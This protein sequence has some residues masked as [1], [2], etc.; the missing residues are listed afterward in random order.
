MFEHIYVFMC[1]NVIV[2]I[3]I[4]EHVYI[5]VSIEGVHVYKCA[6]ICVSARVCVEYMS[7]CA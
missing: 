7:I 5:Y 2:Q 4:Y 3:S 6:C 1:K